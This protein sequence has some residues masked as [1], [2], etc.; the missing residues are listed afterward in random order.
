M[1]IDI[2][3]VRA[4]RFRVSGMVL[5]SQGVPVASATAFSAVPAASTAT[6]HGFTDRRRRPLCGCGV[7]PGDYTLAVGG[8]TWS[9]PIA[10]TGRP[11]IRRV[12][13]DHRDGR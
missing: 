5:D 4:R 6:S 12:A 7:E 3:A 1:S 9:T 13:D 2:A 8:G 10:S 11:E